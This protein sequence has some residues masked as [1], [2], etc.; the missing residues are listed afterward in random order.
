MQA[1]TMWKSALALAVLAVTSLAVL[2]GPAA[3]RVL[4]Q[5]DSGAPFFFNGK[6]WASKQAFVE[7]ARCATRGFSE[8]EA[9]E[10][11]GALDRVLAQAPAAPSSGVI[12][13]YFHVISQG[14][15]LANGDVPLAMIQAQMNVLNAAY[16]PAGWSFTLGG[17]DRTVNPTWYRMEPGTQAEAE[18]KAA[19]RKGTAADLNIY[20]ANPGGSLLGW[21]SF[22]F[23]YVLDPKDD[24]V[25]LLYSSLP[26]GSAAPYNEGDTA[27][28]EVGHWMGLFHT[29][30]FGCTNRNDEV[31]DTPAERY[32][33]F[34]CPVGRNSCP[35]AGLDPIHNFM[36]YVDDFCMFEF[37]GGQATRMENMY[38][39]Y[40]MGR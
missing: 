40:R 15:G 36:D 35:Q 39:A 4:A 20:T 30:Q 18:A 11:Q 6:L 7:R 26:G 28:H 14:P 1:K 17:V 37:S 2:T 31:S 25:V 22:P 34:G 10:I 12:K 24:G 19:L 33:A 23:F 29:F 16:A 8:F 3:E 38:A 27:T 32:P 21:S 5:G 9:R 13:V